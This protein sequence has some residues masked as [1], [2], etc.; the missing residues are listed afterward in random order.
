MARPLRLEFEGAF[1][2]ITARGNDRRDIFLDDEDRQV[3]LDML[4]AA[5][6]RYN[7]ILHEYCQMTDHY[8]LVIETPERTL[9]RGMQWL[10][11][12]YAQYFNRRHNRVGHLFQGRFHAVLVDG[13]NYL[14][15]LCRYV[16]R[17]PVRAKGMVTHPGEWPWSSY[18]AKA[19]LASPPP[20]LTVTNTLVEFHP[21][22]LEAA[23]KNYREFANA[24]DADDPSNSPWRK[25][26]SRMYLADEEW[27]ASIQAKID[28]EPRSTDHPRPQRHPRRPKIDEILSAVAD[29]AGSTAESI[30]RERGG[31]CRM[32]VAWLG[33]FDGIHFRRTIADALGISAGRVTTLLA[34]CKSGIA[35]DVKLRGLIENA[36]NKLTNRPPPGTYVPKR[37]PPDLN[38]GQ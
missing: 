25:L 29:A 24:P 15:T 4:G 10:N 6:A 26:R 9:S 22:D 12:R 27:I 31:R 3:F 5:I 36:G 21:T 33:V 34:E 35:Q 23:R 16:V 18:R 28:E 19:G 32:A 30:R 13:E 1:W 7:W 17:N 8:H 20:W 37:T 14:V 38:R 2:H 11:S